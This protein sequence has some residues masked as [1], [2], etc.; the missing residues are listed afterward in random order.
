MARDIVAGIR[1][2]S[3][4]TVHQGHASMHSHVGE[5]RS[6]WLAHLGRI[7][8]YA[9]RHLLHLQRQVYEL[10]HRAVDS[11]IN[12][13]CEIHESLKA[14][15]RSIFIGMTVDKWDAKLVRQVFLL[16]TANEEIGLEFDQVF[17]DLKCIGIIYADM[18]WLCLLH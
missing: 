10:P 16:Q 11:N 14:C 1:A 4:R 13:L 2:A 6:H 5:Y 7:D 8:S 3:L 15:I 17:L 12:I 18:P 9:S